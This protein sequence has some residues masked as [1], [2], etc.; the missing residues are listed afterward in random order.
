ML[1]SSCFLPYH[2]LP[3]RFMNVGGHFF[4]E[5]KDTWLNGAVEVELYKYEKRKKKIFFSS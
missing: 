3:T 4:K 1:I 2:A 5:E